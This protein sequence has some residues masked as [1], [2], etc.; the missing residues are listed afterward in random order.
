MSGMLSQHRGQVSRGERFEFGKNWARFLR[1]LNDE[2]ITL[3]EQSLRQML[4][5]ERLDGETFLDIGSGSG[6]FSLAARRLGAR[7]RSFDYDPASVACTRE[8]RRRFFPNDPAWTVEQ[9]SIL[10]REFVADLGRHSIVYSWGVLHHTGEMWT[11]L[12]RV[13]DL[14]ELGG[15]LFIAIYNDQGPITD[16]WAEIKRRYNRHLKP[17]AF[18]YALRVIAAEERKALA[19]YLPN[20]GFRAWIKSWAHYHQQSA[21]G[22]SKWYDWIDW[23]GG[24]PY[25]RATVEQIVDWYAKDGFCLQKL[26][27]LSDGYGCNEFVFVREGELGQYVDS[28][29]PGGTSF[30]RQFAYRVTAAPVRAGQWWTAALPASAAK[31]DPDGLVLFR[32]STLAGPISKRDGQLILAD[33]AE[34][35]A[36][37][38]RSVF[39]VADAELVRGPHDGFAPAGGHMWGWSIP[40]FAPLADN[41]HTSGRSP[42]YVFQGGRQLPLPHS[43]HDDIRDQGL[44]RFSHWGSFMWFSTLQNTDPNLALQEFALAIPREKMPR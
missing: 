2:R 42:V 17:L 14:V 31:F 36:S 15:V 10:D 6:L 40:E 43:L 27:D 32:D 1:R 21:R 13:K 30:V 22:M 23:I 34:S 11:A 3:A 37:L 4:G 41:E 9:G 18:L 29:I 12:D 19:G 7:V 25:E 39:H 24:Y 38:A 26:H 28:R 20:G 44:G 35:E 5:R 33:A 16:R 8:L